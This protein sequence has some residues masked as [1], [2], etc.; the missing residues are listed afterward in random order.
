MRIT[1]FIL[2]YHQLLSEIHLTKVL[3][4][5]LPEL[6]VVLGGVT[7]WKPSHPPRAGQSWQRPHGV[8]LK[9]LL[10]CQGAFMLQHARHT[11]APPAPADCRGRQAPLHFVGTVDTGNSTNKKQGSADETCPLL[12]EPT[13]ARTC[14]PH[15]GPRM[16]VGQLP[17]CV[18]QAR[19][20][21]QAS[22]GDHSN[23]SSGL[24]LCCW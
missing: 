2:Q 22:T 13:S 7:A 23:I 9:P 1:K 5:A 10:C 20:C 4:L 21:T 12:G 17:G 18:A 16:L 15:I 24:Q 8:E 6:R 3:L 14:C 11:Q 19:T